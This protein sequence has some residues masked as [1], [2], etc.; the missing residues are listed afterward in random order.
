METKQL[1]DDYS[2]LTIFIKDL[3]DACKAS[4]E[5]IYTPEQLAMIEEIK[6]KHQAE[7]EPMLAELKRLEGNLKAITIAKKETQRGTMH[8]FSYT[9]PRVTWD[10]KGLDGYMVAHPEIKA[11]RKV[12]DPSVSVRK[13]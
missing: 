11:F 5:A 2:R 1:I 12:G 7:I 10:N 3:E 9:K 4:I 6:A 13:I 8:M